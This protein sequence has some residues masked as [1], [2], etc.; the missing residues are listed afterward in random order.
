MSALSTFIASE[1]E[2]FVVL[3]DQNALCGCRATENCTILL[4]REKSLVTRQC[5]SNKILLP[6]DR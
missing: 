2:R 6:F 1:A 4:P 3:I 5:D